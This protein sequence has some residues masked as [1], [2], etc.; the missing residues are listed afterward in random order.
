MH[1]KSKLIKKI[2]PKIYPTFV[3]IILSVRKYK[4]YI[5]YAERY[6]Y[7]GAE[8]ALNALYLSIRITRF[9]N[10]YTRLGH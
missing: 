3:I 2:I 5:L 7:C 1:F 9:A 6:V 10:K 4:L 8:M